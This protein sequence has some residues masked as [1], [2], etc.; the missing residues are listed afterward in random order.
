[1]GLF[2]TFQM[3]MFLEIKLEHEGTSYCAYRFFRTLEDKTS[4]SHALVEDI[5]VKH[6]SAIESI[7]IIW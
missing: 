3:E 6:E 4:L 1:M 7:C 5:K 2:K